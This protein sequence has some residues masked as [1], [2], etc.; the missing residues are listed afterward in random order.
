MKEKFNLAHLAFFLYIKIMI[1]NPML[2][3]YY[4]KHK[5][6]H[7]LETRHGFV[8]FTVTMKYILDFAKKIG[9]KKILDIG[10]G[11]GR[12]SVALSREGFDVTAVEIVEHNVKI[13][14][15]KHEKVK[16]W[17]GDARNLDFLEDES[18]DLTLILGP[19]Y[20]LHTDNEKIKAL[21]EAKRVTKKGGLIFAGYVLNDYSILD[22]CFDESRMADLVEKG[23]VDEEF[24][25]R[26]TEDDLYDYVRIS[27]ID[28]LNEKCGLE[29]K[30]IFSPDGP[31]DFMRRKL[32]AMSE[33]NFKLF[34]D[35]QMKNA[36]RH[37]LLG[38][39]SHLVDVLIYGGYKKLEKEEIRLLA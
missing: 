5:E 15:R 3:Q 37:E 7:R 17:Q 28:R 4:S 34:L 18:F 23:A 22:Y 14:E 2:E 10:A 29:R 21:G 24:H 30:L 19:L 36:T 1:L 9:A 39:G 6:D 11:T 32:N 13:L 16:I 31:A 38:A 33:E 20:H 12:Y 35:Y 27:D 26:T 8:E 25:I